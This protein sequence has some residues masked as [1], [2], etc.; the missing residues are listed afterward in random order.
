MTALQR[1]AGLLLTVALAL[2]PLCAAHSGDAPKAEIFRGEV[3]ALAKLLAEKGVK[4]DADAAPAWRA[5]KTADGKLYPLVKDAGARMFFKDDAMLNRPLR[6]T[7]RL[8]PGTGLLQI[9]AVHSEVRGKLHEIYY[10]CDICTIR[11]YEPGIC[12]C[13]GAPVERR[14]EPVRG[15]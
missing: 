5:L 2:L 8:V 6:V 7:G 3:V 12:E 14:E 15:N 4:L 11:C 9:V 13:C 1:R 10:W